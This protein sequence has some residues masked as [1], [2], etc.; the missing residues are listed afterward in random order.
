MPFVWIETDR[1]TVM[2]VIVVTLAAYA[3]EEC[4]DM[5]NSRSSTVTP[6]GRLLFAP[7]SHLH[8]WNRLEVTKLVNGKAGIQTQ[9]GFGVCTFYLCLTLRGSGFRCW[10]GYLF[11]NS[12]LMTE[13]YLSL[14]ANSTDCL[15]LALS[16]DKGADN[17]AALPGLWWKCHKKCVMCSVVRL[18]IDSWWHF[19]H[20]NERKSEP[21]RL[22]YL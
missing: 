7:V 6:G 13:T 12:S 17:R 5:V 9:S 4:L 3:L 16:S 21:H 14:H 19:P 22:G 1:I 2:S 11:T 20:F 8:N 15:N 10:L 18:A